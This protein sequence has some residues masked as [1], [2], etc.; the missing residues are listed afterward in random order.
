VAWFVLGMALAILPLTLRNHRVAGLWIPVN[1]QFW[2]AVY[3]STAVATQPSPDRMRWRDVLSQ[4][5]EVAA[6]SVGRELA[7]VYEPMSIPE[8]LLLEK[9]YRDAALAN[10]REQ[11]GT[12]LTNV[13]RSLWSYH[14]HTTAAYLPVFRHYQQPGGTWP[15]WGSP[16]T[17]ADPAT[18]PGGDVYRIFGD[19][20]TLLGLAG[21]GLAIVRRDA[22][23]LAPAAVHACFA[24]AH[25]LSW[26]DFTYLYLRMPFNALFAIYLLDGGLSRQAPTAVRFG[27]LATAAALV[28]LL[29]LSLA[30]VFV[31]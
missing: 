19:L 24:V 3:G 29:S 5:R 22:R 13:L 26:M 11:P 15:R 17:P 21:A 31:R 12:Y 25:S 20:L 30:E 10:L 6:R 28:A 2:T 27:T 4:A 9:G 1:A 7:G 16:G 8:N 18:W 23:L 14:A